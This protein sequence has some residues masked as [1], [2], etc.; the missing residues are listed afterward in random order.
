M[1]LNSVESVTR[2]GQVW[3]Y[4]Y[5]FNLGIPPTG[6][7][8]WGHGVDSP[9]G[10]AMGAAGNLTPGM[11]MNYGPTDS[12]TVYD[13]TVTHFERN[14][15][16]YVAT[17]QTPAGIITQYGY[18]TRGNLENI[19]RTPSSGSGN[20]VESAVYPTTCTNIVTCNEPTS[21]TDAN[22]N[23][24]AFSYDPVHGGVLTIT[25]PAVAN[26]AGT[27][28]QPQIR[29]TYVQ[30]NAWYLSSAGAMT[31][32]ANPIWVLST[33]SY[34]MTGP[35]A[36]SGSGCALPNDQVVTSY[37]YGPASG[38][39]NLLPRGKAVTAQG[40]TLQTCYG[41][42]ENGN[43]IWETSPNANPSSCPSY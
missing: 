19:T 3:S 12:L 36:S 42:D 32:D 4:D 34:C 13:G 20:I 8:S 29:R 43:R 38:P 5:A 10:A 26:P 7:S 40:R 17:Q 9:L 37:D 6:Y 22:G 31:E 18:D 2:E 41:H 11:E 28:V 24:S 39:N 16:N 33:E 35:P 23:T 30:L 15:R 21:V 14:T 25:G 27:Q 1:L